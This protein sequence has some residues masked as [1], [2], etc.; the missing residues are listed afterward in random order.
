MRFF[1]SLRAFSVYR[2]WTLV[3]IRS[4]GRAAFGFSRFF[5]PGYLWCPLVFF[6]S[7]IELIRVHPKG[8]LSPGRW[9]RLLKLAPLT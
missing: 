8:L 1:C 5:S 3:L 9:P 4:A 6:V 2:G 7:K